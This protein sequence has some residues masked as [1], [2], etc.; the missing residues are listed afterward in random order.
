MPQ[1]GK[2]NT[3]AFGAFISHS[4]RDAETAAAIKKHLESAGIRCWKAPDDVLPGE[5]WPEAILR[6]IGDSTTMILVWSAHSKASSEVSKE[7][8]LAMRHKVSVVPFRIENVP[9]SIEWEYHLAN[10]HWMD[11]FTGDLDSHLDLLACHLRKLLPSRNSSL[12]AEAGTARTLSK[13]VAATPHSNVDSVK[14]VTSGGPITFK[15]S[16]LNLYDAPKPSKKLPQRRLFRRAVSTILLMFFVVGLGAVIRDFEARSTDAAKSDNTRGRIPSEVTAPPSAPVPHNSGTGIHS[17][18]DSKFIQHAAS[19]GEP[20]PEAK[21]EEQIKRAS[22]ASNEQEKQ[23]ALKRFASSAEESAKAS[24]VKLNARQ[25]E[26]EHLSGTSIA[27]ETKANQSASVRSLAE[28]D[29]VDI[30]R[31]YNPR[32]TYQKFSPAQLNEAEVLINSDKA[33]KSADA[34]M[35]A[36][37]ARIRSSL[38]QN[39]AKR[40]SLKAD[41]LNWLYFRTAVLNGGVKICL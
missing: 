1:N 30:S 22:A 8:T 21:L 12:N 17:G 24:A 14:G 10:T 38:S 20:S 15:V 13:D 25:F 23:V 36:L 37:Y 34:E 29:A 11:A 35:E 2:M 7:L 4:S 41:Q 28:S 3:K 33:C 27:T 39:S 32:V 6:A 19:S 31:R 9:A 16:E 18:S 5:S 26:I 40:D